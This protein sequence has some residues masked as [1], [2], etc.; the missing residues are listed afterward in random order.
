MRNL[1]NC[2]QSTPKSQ[3]WVWWDP[4]IQSRKCTGLIFTGELC[5]NT[6][7]NDE[8]FQEELTCRFKIDMRNMTNLTQ[9]LESPKNLHF[10]GLLLDKVYNVWA[11]KVP[12]SYLPWHWRMMQNLKKNWLVVWKMI[13]GIW[14]I[15]TRALKSRKIGTLVGSY[16]P[17]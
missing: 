16:Y 10:N 13:W 7:N 11:K 15:F 3:N 8:T 4:F 2:H 17:K 14:Q 6:L 1:A 12:R 5:V 9:Q